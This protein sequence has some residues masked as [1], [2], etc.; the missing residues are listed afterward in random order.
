MSFWDSVTCIY[1]CTVLALIT[2][3]IVGDRVGGCQQ[4]VGLVCKCPCIHSCTKPCAV[5]HCWCNSPC[6]LMYLSIVPSGY[7][8][9][10][11]LCDTVLILLYSQTIS[12][13]RSLC[14]PWSANVCPV[15]P[16]C[17][18]CCLPNSLETCCVW[19]WWIHA[20]A[21]VTWLVNLHWHCAQP[22]WLMC[23]VMKVVTEAIYI[24]TRT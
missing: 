1:P 21:H 14:L 4:Q 15:R 8:K 11:C 20:L 2:V 19:G 3:N 10:L 18:A 9:W 12:A 13:S 16:I 6:Q 24:V 23:V 17:I 22:P 5:G 7:A